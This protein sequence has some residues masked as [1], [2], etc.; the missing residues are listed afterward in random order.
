MEQ[1]DLMELVL[2][3][4]RRIDS[5]HSLKGDFTNYCG[6]TCELLVQELKKSQV[7]GSLISGATI[8]I[9]ETD[10]KIGHYWVETGRLIV[11][12]TA[13]QFKLPKMV[14]SRDDEQYS[15]YE[16]YDVELTF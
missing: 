5:Q 10:K 11:D 1:L 16:I 4:R 9:W 7:S 14:F 8:P 6:N 2:N 3:I 15:R 13:D 12:P